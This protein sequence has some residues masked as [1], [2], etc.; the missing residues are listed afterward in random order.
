MTVL[1]SIVDRLKAQ[2]PVL[3]NRVSI[4]R[5]LTNPDPVTLPEAWVYRWNARVTPN[6]TINKITQTRFQEIV[7][8]V[9]IEL[10]DETEGVDHYETVRDEIETALIGFIPDGLEQPLMAVRDEIE[11]IAEGYTVNRFVYALDEF[12]REA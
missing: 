2:C 12:I 3:S 8:Q 4:A 7:V 1:S 10:E 11:H 5:S 6:V 9:A